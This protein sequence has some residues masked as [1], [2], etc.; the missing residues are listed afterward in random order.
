MMTKSSLGRKGLFRLILADI[1]VWSRAVGARDQEK[2]RQ[3]QGLML[4]LWRMTAY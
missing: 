2:R 1:S 3:E 4:M